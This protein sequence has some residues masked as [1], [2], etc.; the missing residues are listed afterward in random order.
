V[1]QT[2]QPPTPSDA[3][4]AS[5]VEARRAGALRLGTEYPFEAHFTRPQGGPWLHYLDEGPTGTSSPDDS[6]IL[7]VHGNPSWSFH[8]RRLIER[9]GSEHRVVA[10]DLIGCG[11]SEQPLDWPYRLRDHVD[12]VEALVESLDLRRITL[13][14][15]DWGGAIGLGVA[16][17]Q[18]ERF[19]RLVILNSGAFRSADMPPR[20]ALGRIPVLGT[21][22]IRGLG[23]FSR[24]ALPW[25]VERKQ[26]SEEERLAYLLPYP[27]W[28]RRIAVNAFV[29]DIP[30]REDHPS[31]D[32]L[33]RIEEALPRLRSKPTTLIW[34]ERDWCFTT[35]FRD[36]Y[37]QILPDAESVGLADAGHWVLEDDPDQVL[38]AMG[39]FLARHPLPASSEDAG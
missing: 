13:V 20:I 16:G 34:G 23:L 7:C 8:W 4:P 21:L 10:P 5:L 26:W 15:Q 39:D 35:A 27:D 37:R 9:F 38:D 2:L 11:F 22:G 25:A 3:P 33:V 19:E 32:E 36:R 1:S 17:R 18:P 14:V 24:L 12:T 31:W 28:R 6:P 30:M 29:K